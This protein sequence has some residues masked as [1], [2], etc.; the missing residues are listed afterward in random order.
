MYS[1][2]GFKLLDL[3]GFECL[4]KMEFNASN[5]A[6]YDPDSGLIVAED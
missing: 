4:L 6:L 5:C 3:Y 1:L 2:S